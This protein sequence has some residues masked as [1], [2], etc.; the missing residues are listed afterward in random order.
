MSADNADS[1]N[2][3]TDGKDAGSD[4][5][6]KSQSGST[7]KTDISGQSDITNKASAGSATS[8]VSAPEASASEAADRQKVDRVLNDM[9]Q[10]V[11]PITGDLFSGMDDGAGSAN[12]QALSLAEEEEEARAARA[13][14]DL[15]DQT[16]VERIRTKAS[17]VRAHD[18]AQ[19]TGADSRFTRDIE[20]ERLAVSIGSQNRPP[21]GV[22]C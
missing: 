14:Y 17:I 7:D 10:E 12:L 15:D 3:K 20:E 9:L 16:P 21:I 18:P 4:A 2:A 11:Q 19:M 13:L 5:S 22:Q 8:A 1:T 6:S